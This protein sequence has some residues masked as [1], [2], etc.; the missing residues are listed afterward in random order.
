MFDLNTVKFTKDTPISTVIAHSVS[1]LSKHL[2]DYQLDATLHAISATLRSLKPMLIEVPTGG[3]KSWICVSI[4]YVMSLIFQRAGY[5]NRRTLVICPTDT[6]VEQ[7]AEKL[8][9]AGG[10]VAIFCASLKMKQTEGTI[11]VGTPLS[12][13]NSI[14]MFLSLNIGCVIVD[15]A[16]GHVDTSKGVVAALKKQ[17]PLLREFGMTATPYRTVEKYI[18]RVNSYERKAP[19]DASM[20]VDPYY[21]E[22]V[23]KVDGERLVQAGHLIPMLTKNIGMH[24]DTKLLKIGTGGRFTTDS[25]RAVFITRATNVAIISDMLINTKDRKMV[26]IFCQNIEHAEMIHEIMTEKLSAK[27]KQ[28]TSVLYHSK[29]DKDVARLRLEEFNKGKHRFMI[30][31]RGLTTGYDNE[32]V[33]GI[34]V[35][36]TTESPTLLVQII[37]RGMRPIRTD[38]RFK[39]PYCMLYDYGENLPRHF[40]DGDLFRPLIRPVGK[41]LKEPPPRLSFACPCC[42]HESHAVASAWYHPLTE[43]GYIVNQHGY[44]TNANGAVLI[45]DTQRRP[46]AAHLQSKCHGVIISPDGQVSLCQHTWEGQLCHECG[47]LNENRHECCQYCLA[48]FKERREYEREGG[49]RRSAFDF[50]KQTLATDL[51]QPIDARIIGF[52]VRFERKQ[53][54]QSN[55]YLRGILQL[56]VQINAGPALQDGKVTFSRGTIDRVKIYFDEHHDYVLRAKQRKQMVMNALWGQELSIE[57]A[58]NTPL[59]RH[60]KKVEYFWAKTDSGWRYADVLKLKAIAP[61]QQIFELACDAEQKQ[62]D[63]IN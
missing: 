49:S 44:F 6:L 17:N 63:T 41:N 34:V 53:D 46:V 15:E 3:G 18:Y 20:A 24:Y 21:D 37:G 16:H 14:D 55:L 60:P 11:I 2:R 19:N 10:D 48:D 62:P 40:P 23:Y 7:N 38:R 35:L 29:V 36:S 47:V 28:E 39:K 58:M 31:V 42:S 22:L 30:S 51:Y 59:T 8:R 12:I 45:C 32:R 25:E 61:D 5:D 27:R 56:T 50:S 52:N 43:S 57:E 1:V 26:M 9:L 13:A 54:R 33:D 4:A